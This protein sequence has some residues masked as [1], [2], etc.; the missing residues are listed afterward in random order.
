MIEAG[1]QSRATS[2]ERA[3]PSPRCRLTHSWVF[4]SVKL[5]AFDQ[6]RDRIFWRG[7]ALSSDAIKHFIGKGGRHLK[8][9][10]ALSGTFIGVFDSVKGGADVHIYGPREGIAMVQHVLACM[11]DEFYTVLSSLERALGSLG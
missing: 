9:L 2:H 4:D 5:G 6:E 3:G 10:E 8:R 7:G 11:D 1:S